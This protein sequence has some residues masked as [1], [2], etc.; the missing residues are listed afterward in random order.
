MSNPP[1]PAFLV[2][3]LDIGSSLAP[4]DVCHPPRPPSQGEKQGLVSQR[5]RE[6]AVVHLPNLRQAMIHWDQRR[7]LEDRKE[8]KKMSC[9][10]FHLSVVANSQD[11]GVIGQ[12]AAFKK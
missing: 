5:A 7:R 9:S 6:C 12:H 1:R 2:S 8:L 4:V 10:V 11:A 3:H